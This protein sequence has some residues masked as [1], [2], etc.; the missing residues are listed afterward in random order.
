MPGRGQRGTVT[1]IIHAVQPPALSA[2]G[3][4]CQGRPGQAMACYLGAP[5]ATFSRRVRGTNRPHTEPNEDRGWLLDARAGSGP[6]FNPKPAALALL[7][8]RTHGR[9]DVLVEPEEV[10]RIVA[11]L[12]PRQ[13][14][15]GGSGV[16][17]ADTRFAFVTQ[18]VDVRSIV[19]LAQR[20]GEIRDPCLSQRPILGTFVEGGHV[21]H[22]PSGA[23]GKRRRLGRHTGHGP[24]QDS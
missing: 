21:C 11:G 24:T 22:D 16:G 5:W 3:P 23:V 9:P 10:G 20:S 14:V 13:P 1:G 6:S 7:P 4:S 17:L 12:D 19:P 2:A 15:P 18:K 8:L